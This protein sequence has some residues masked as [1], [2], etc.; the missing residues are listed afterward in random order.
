MWNIGSHVSNTLML[1]FSPWYLCSVTE[2]IVS[3][4]YPPASRHPPLTLESWPPPTL[5]CPCCKLASLPY[6]SPRLPIGRQR[7]PPPMAQETAVKNLNLSMGD[8]AWLHRRRRWRRKNRQAHLN[9]RNQAEITDNRSGV[10]YSNSVK[11]IPECIVTI[12]T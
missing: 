7:R 8:A 4:I 10:L 12:G 5:G 3:K 9:I 1:F 6:L 11:I 2:Q